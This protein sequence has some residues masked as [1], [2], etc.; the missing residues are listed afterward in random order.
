MPYFLI[1]VSTRRNLDLCL[2]FSLAGFPSSRNGLWG[3]WDIAD[4]DYVSFLY[5]AKIY[6]L[7]RVQ[8]HETV[9]AGEAA[10]PWEPITF[11][12]SGRTYDFPF[13]LRLTPI[14]LF[15]QSVVNDRLAYVAQNLLLRGGY[16]K[17]HFQADQTT[18]QYVSQLG[19]VANGPHESHAGAGMAF[20]PRLAFSTSLVSAPRVYR[21]QETFLHV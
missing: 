5:G 14:R 20:L 7:Y 15:E 6:N 9:S 1:A 17:T 8:G 10:A 12:E 19:T 4:G 18:L 11:K 2:R 21:F 13:R 16:A 3:Y